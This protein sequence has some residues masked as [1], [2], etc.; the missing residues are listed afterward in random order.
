M[1]LLIN[2]NKPKTMQAAVKSCGA[3]PH[4]SITCGRACGSSALGVIDR[5][6]DSLAA[7]VVAV[8]VVS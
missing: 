2:C 4:L 6:R 1:H 3:H 8:V 7:V 5:D